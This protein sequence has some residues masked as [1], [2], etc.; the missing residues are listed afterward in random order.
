MA[1]EWDDGV[2][3]SDDEEADDADMSGSD[4][5]DDANH[6]GTAGEHRKRSS[7][8]GHAAENKVTSDEDAMLLDGGSG[9]LSALLQ[10]EVNPP[11]SFTVKHSRLDG[12]GTRRK[13]CFGGLAI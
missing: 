10:L 13:S 3:A 4:E 8:A 11:L 9:G 12:I 5:D 2:S 6:V 1:E 7:N